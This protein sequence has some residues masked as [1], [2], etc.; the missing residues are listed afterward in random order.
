MRG[1]TV[2][3]MPMSL[4]FT[5]FDFCNFFNRYLAIVSQQLNCVF[6]VFAVLY[7]NPII[8]ELQVSIKHINI[9]LLCFTHRN[10]VVV[11][12]PYYDGLKHY[13]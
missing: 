2:Y 6:T 9:V 11:L 5:I 4:Y 3:C 13:N 10:G 12:I 1:N 7:N 8:A